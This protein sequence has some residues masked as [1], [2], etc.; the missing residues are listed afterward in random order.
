[1]SKKR[2]NSTGKTTK[3][4]TEKTPGKA[5]EKIIFQLDKL[6]NLFK[7]LVKNGMS[8][9]EWEDQNQRIYLKTALAAPAQGSHSSSHQASD[10][11]SAQ[12][13]ATPYIASMPSLT[14]KSDLASPQSPNQD[15]GTAHLPKNHKQV[16]SPF[17]GTFY[18]SA[19]PESDAYVQVGKM[20]KRGD[21]LCIVEAMKL[22]NEIETEFNGTI[23]SILVENGQP[24]EFG[25]PLFI[26]EAQ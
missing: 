6:E 19:S 7:V 17:V 22:M 21:P 14:S 15:P 11:A 23:M 9:I 12:N 13:P 18:R 16:F 26:I 2:T 3:K 5:T 20:V 8:E 10:L 4:T 25:E 1:M 24:V